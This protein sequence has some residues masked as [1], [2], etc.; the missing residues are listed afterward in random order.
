MSVDYRLLR[1]DEVDAAADLWV[2]YH[3]DIESAQH[4][5]WRREFRGIPQLLTHTRVAVTPDG[6]LLSII[7][8]WPLTVYDA[9]GEPQRVGR[10]SHVF[11]REEARGQGHAARLL[12]LTITA[13]RDDG[14]LWSLL[15]TS[16]EAR[17]L[18]ERHGWRAMPVRQV[19]CVA[20]RT[21]EH[22][23]T[24]ACTV[25]PY[26]PEREANGWGRIAAI[27]RA[28]NT[29]RLLTAVRDSA[30]WRYIGARVGWWLESGQAHVLVATPA[31]EDDICAYAIAAFSRERGF[32]LAEL[33]ALPGKEGALPALL[34]DVIGRSEGASPRG[35]LYL[36]HEPSL[37]DALGVLCTQVSY[38][39]DDEYM[40]RAIAPD[41][42]VRRLDALPIAPGNV[43]WMLY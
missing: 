18:Y 7:H 35:R 24:R 11:T 16:D 8:Y 42:D 3:A 2:G 14:C 20:T 29:G 30:Y 34:S 6:A 22:T 4:Q 5:A 15:R 23:A 37:D 31:D 10:L 28:Y 27:H 21:T 39:T 19:T 13:M 17:S 32:L 40:V 9:N 43:A 38:R 12:E 25:R 36:P 1:A 33:G 26:D 41:Y